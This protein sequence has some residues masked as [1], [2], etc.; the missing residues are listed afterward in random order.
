MFMLHCSWQEEYS[1]FNNCFV[2]FDICDAIEFLNKDEAN[3]MSGYQHIR[4]LTV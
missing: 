4:I 3:K 2:N 1:E